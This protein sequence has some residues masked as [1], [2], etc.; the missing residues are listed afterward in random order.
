MELCDITLREWLRERNQEITKNGMLGLKLVFHF[1]ISPPGWRKTSTNKYFSTHSLPEKFFLLFQ[2]LKMLNF[3]W[4]FCWRRE[5]TTNYSFR[6]RNFSPA[7]AKCLSGKRALQINVVCL[8][9]SI[10]LWWVSY[11]Y[12]G[13]QVNKKDNMNIF[14]QIVVGINYIHSQGLIHRDIKVFLFWSEVRDPWG[15]YYSIG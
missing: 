2:S 14:K 4:T 13:G 10:V 11:C 15:Y 3:C 8:S 6:S 9:V 5:R 7:A 12:L 1:A